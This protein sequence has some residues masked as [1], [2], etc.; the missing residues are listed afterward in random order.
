[1]ALWARAFLF[2]SAPGAENRGEHHVISLR[3]FHSGKGRTGLALLGIA[4]LAAVALPATAVGKKPKPKVVG[5]V[6]TE[7]NNTS[8]NAVLEFNRLASGLLQ[9]T[10]QVLTGGKGGLENQHGCGAN[11]PFLDTQGEV[12]LTSDGRFLFAV[13]AGSNTIT[14]FRVTSHGLK[15]ADQKSSGG[16]FPYSVTSNGN[17]L[18]V[19]NEKSL[20]IAGFRFSTTGK[21]TPIK[22]SKQP[23]GHGATSGPTGPRQIQFDNTGHVLAVTLLGVQG[24]DTFLVKPNGSAGPAKLNPTAAPLPFGFS[25]D[26]RNQLVV[27]EVHDLT[28]TA[29]GVTSTYKL[30]AGS[31]HTSHIDTKP[32]QGFAPCWLAITKDG[33]FTYVVNTGGGAP[34]G[35]TVTAYRISTSGK[36]TFLQ[37]TPAG[38]PGAAPG[39]K[40]FARTDDV[41]SGDDRFLYVLVPGVFAPSRIDIFKVQSNGHITQIGSTPTNLAP[42]ISGLAAS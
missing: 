10:G 9:Q 11:C 38:A 31:G 33:R 16:K 20:N 34:S 4:A 25:F 19:L 40:E 3:R 14:S 42:G 37:L 17:L 13:N 27:S 24:I 8:K 39:G 26:A 30:N 1:L 22:G 23:L 36:L 12:N 5:T 32:S 2:M 28:G 29:T 21:L 15:R 35:A 18:Y 6:Y 41:L 7:T